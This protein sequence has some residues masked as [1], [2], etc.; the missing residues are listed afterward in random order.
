MT[1]VRGLHRALIERVLGAPGDAPRELRQA[2]FSNEGLTVPLTELLDKVALH[3]YRVTDADVAAAREARFSE[4]QIFEL[5]VCAAI[6]QSTRQHET[7]M[8]ALHAATE[9]R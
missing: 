9:R 7:A 5:V 4:D 1:D 2:A 6:G 3:A 8:A